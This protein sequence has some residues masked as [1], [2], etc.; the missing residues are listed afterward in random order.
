[1]TN[2][3]FDKTNE[4]FDAE[5]EKEDDLQDGTGDG[6]KEDVQEDHLQDGPYEEEVQEDHLEDED[7]I[8]VK[9]KFDN[10]KGDEGKSVGMKKKDKMQDSIENLN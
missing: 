9:K 4:I 6:N 7:D 8:E 3:V 2:G 5:E 1:M 10:V